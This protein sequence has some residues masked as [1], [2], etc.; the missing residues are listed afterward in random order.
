MKTPKI[1]PALAWAMFVLLA[2][3][4][5]SSFILMKRGLESFDFAQIGMLRIATAWIFTVIIAFRKFKFWKKVDTMPSAIVGYFGNAIP[6][7]LFP[8]AV[9][10][11]DSSLV[12]ILNSLVPLFTLI[13]GLIWFGVRVRWIGVTGI[14]LGFAGALWLLLPGLQIDADKLG[15]GIYPIIATVCYALSINTINSKL[16]DLD[17]LSITLFSTSTVGPLALI[18]VFSTDF[19]EIMQTNPNAWLNLGYISIMG[20]V[21]TSLAVILFNYLIKGT[22]SLFAASVTYAIPLVA[23]LWGIWDGEDVG[24]EHLVGMLLI[25]A[26]VYLVNFKG[27]PADRIR[28]RLAKAR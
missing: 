15:F 12:G 28:K 16:K 17:S 3:I 25:L 9:T 4:W 22:S 14:I 18:Y 26:G 6:Y 24:P 19:L 7:I 8:L 11:L 2:L 20:I 21:G 1:N 23:L 27:S 13:I 5:G 10:R